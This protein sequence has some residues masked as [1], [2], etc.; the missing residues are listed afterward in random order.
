MGVVLLGEERNVNGLG[1]AFCLRPETITKQRTDM[2]PTRISLITFNLALALALWTQSS[3]RAEA[4]DKLKALT[5]AGQG[6]EIIMGKL[7]RIRLDRIAYDGL[8]LGEVVKSLIDEAKKRDPEKKGINFVATSNGSTDTPPGEPAEVIDI[9]SI[10]I[11]IMPPLSDVRLV[12]A[13]DAV[14]MVADRPIQYSIEDYGVVFTLRRHEPEHKEAGFAFPG[15][16]PKEFL[17]AV[18]KQYKVNW[19]SVADIPEAVQSV[20]IPA[21]R[22]DRESLEPILRRGRRYGGGFFG[23]TN[24]MGAAVSPAMID[25]RNPLEALVAL[26][27]SLQ[28]AKPE[29]GRLIVEGDF[30]KPSVVMFVAPH[31]SSATSDFQMRAFP[32]KG[33]PK[34]TWDKLAREAEAELGNLAQAQRTPASSWKFVSLRIHRDTGLLVVL[35]PAAFLDAVGSFVTAWQANQKW[36]HPEAK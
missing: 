33:I 32:L 6:R 26:Y 12:E 1:F 13:L 7:D 14:V 20:Q 3:G 9:N 18:E 8:P 24:G 29:L 28:Q 21:L 30:A 11:K 27:N 23:G 31:D 22:M 36:N 16:T 10:I 35:G 15:G 19:S 4:N 25:E 2:K 5:S 17:A 34:D